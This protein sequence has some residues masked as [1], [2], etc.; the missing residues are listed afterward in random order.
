MNPLFSSRKSD[1]ETPPDLFHALNDEFS[2]YADLAASENNALVDRYLDKEFDALSV[3]WVDVFPKGVVN[4]CNPPY[5]R[6][7]G[8]WHKKAAQAR[9]YNSTVILCPA[10]TDTQWF[11]DLV[12][13]HASEIRLIK[14]RLKFRLDSKTIG[15]APFPSMIVVYD[16][17]TNLPKP[18]VMVCDGA[19]PGEDE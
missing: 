9:K 13:A 4:W 6:Q 14:G 12:W 16:H 8:L 17:W 18:K 7:I 19:Y 10:R 3:D 11:H 1:W 5:G 15:T 2:F